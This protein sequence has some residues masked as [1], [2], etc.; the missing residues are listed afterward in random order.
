MG[1]DGHTLYNDIWWY[2]W[3]WLYFI[4]NNIYIKHCRSTVDPHSHT[5]A[6][7]VHI[8]STSIYIHLRFIHF[9]VCSLSLNLWK[10]SQESILIAD[11]A[12]EQ[13]VGESS[14]DQVVWKRPFQHIPTTS[15]T[16]KIIVFS[17]RN[18]FFKQRRS[19]DLRALFD[20]QWFSRNFHVSTR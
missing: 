18:A 5:F 7:C 13:K 9:S 11:W 10:R 19:L 17:R 3:L 12:P 1:H 6:W 8:S 2:L 14:N 16:F 4:Y 20:F 15:Q